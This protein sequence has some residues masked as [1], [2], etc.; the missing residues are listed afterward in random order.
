[1][2]RDRYIKPRIKNMKKPVSLKFTVLKMTSIQLKKFLKQRI[3]II[4]QK[5]NKMA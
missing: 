1:M 3:E 5:D 2:Q 4:K